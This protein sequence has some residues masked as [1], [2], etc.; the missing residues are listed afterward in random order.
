MLASKIQQFLPASE[1]QKK[2]LLTSTAVGLGVLAV[3]TLANYAVSARI[4]RKR[5][6]AVLAKPP[7]QYP[8][9]DFVEWRNGS[10]DPIH[11][12]M[13]LV[14]YHRD[15]TL[16]EAFRRYMASNA[17]RISEHLGYL[18]VPELKTLPLFKFKRP[19]ITPEHR[20]RLKEQAK[21]KYQANH[22]KTRLFVTG[23]TGFIGQEF[24]FQTAADPAFEEV[25]CLVWDKEIP[26][27]KTPEEFR[28]QI[29][30]RLDIADSQ[31]DKFKFYPG[32]V[33]KD[34]FGLSEADYEYVAANVTHILHCAASV[35][36]EAPYLNSFR[37]NVL[38]ARN[39]C[40]F[41]Q[42]IQDMPNSKFVSLVLIETCFIHGR[43][44]GKCREDKLVFPTDYYNN[45]YEVTKAFASIESE[46]KLADGL[47]LTQLCP[48]IVIGRAKDG[49]NN[50]DVKVCN[51]PIN[52]FGR[53]RHGT[54]SESN[55]PLLKRLEHYLISYLVR[56][57]PADPHATLDLVCVD[58]VVQG[59]KAALTRPQAVAERIHLATAPGS[60][61]TLTDFRKVLADELKVKVRY[62]NP[63]YHRWIRDPFIAT[64]LE[65]R[66]KDIMPKL[67]RLTSIFAA[68]SEWPQPKHEVGKDVTVLGI[69]APRPDLHEALRIV[70]RHNE[71]V[72]QFGRIRG[73]KVFQRE[74][75]WE[76][77]IEAMVRDFSVRHPSQIP[78]E[79]FRRIAVVFAE[80]A[81]EHPE[82][83]LSTLSPNSFGSHEPK[84]T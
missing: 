52:T 9:S 12:D 36:F 14:D 71:H 43:Q 23:V 42:K 41:A 21:A 2:C 55:P 1:E 74:R 47:R 80:E 38:G 39:A 60:Q 5:K 51:A 32:D 37:A 19:T 50:G 33:S 15:V 53:Y 69:Y 31:Y 68:Y 58:R 61:I 29:L 27:G 30:S 65:K 56:H 62:V 34:R 76:K 49:N 10:K 79:E 66:D 45:F 22:Y 54:S 46:R 40:I 25:I 7:D 75:H 83:V 28:N 84:A 24:L 44:V 11:S 20:A 26:A 73:E 16:F 72:Q 77:F 67:R 8:V 63:V 82:K 48:A 6:Q 13:L 18:F 70:A 57:Y 78:A 81:E 64:L 4:M 17:S 35:S 59:M 3:G